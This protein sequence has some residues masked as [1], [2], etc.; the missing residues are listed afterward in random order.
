M[1]R[2]RERMVTQQ[3]E[4]N[5]APGGFDLFRISKSKDTVDLCANTLRAYNRLGLPFYKQG[6]VIFISKA[7]LEQ[8]IRSGRGGK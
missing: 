8:F 6:K 7:E 4:T 5:R 2:Y 1:A 3:A